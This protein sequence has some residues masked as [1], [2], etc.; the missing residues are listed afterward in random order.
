MRHRS[1]SR[2]K[3]R[4]NTKANKQ[5]VEKRWT[6]KY[7]INCCA[8]INKNNYCSPKMKKQCNK[9]F[10]LNTNKSAKRN[11]LKESRIKRI[12]QIK[13]KRANREYF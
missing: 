10:N 5:N 3:T 12:Q 4:K 7:C 13:Y 9:C 1:R 11:V 6:Q 8:P 2:S